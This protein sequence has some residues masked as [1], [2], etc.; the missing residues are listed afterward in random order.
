MSAGSITLSG[1]L[2]NSRSYGAETIKVV[3]AAEDDKGDPKEITTRYNFD[4]SWADEVNQFVD[5]I[6]NNKPVIQGSSSEAY[7]T[8][9][10]L[11]R[12]YEADREWASLHSN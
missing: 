11:S 2:T 8:M 1:I 6:I 3:Y 7:K 4:H 9:E 12:I 5:C 10:L